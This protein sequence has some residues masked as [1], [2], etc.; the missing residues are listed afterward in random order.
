[1]DTD[2]YDN[3]MDG[4]LGSRRKAIEDCTIATGW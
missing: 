1:M 4:N 3:E 2:D